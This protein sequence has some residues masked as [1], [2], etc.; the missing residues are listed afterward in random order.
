MEHEVPTGIGG[1]G[2]RAPSPGTGPGNLTS[3]P[4]LPVGP[5]ASLASSPL[6]LGAAQILPLIHGRAVSV[7]AR[8]RV[9]G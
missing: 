7:P 6:P 4:K 8:S 1:S 3:A 9:P 2:H 5:P